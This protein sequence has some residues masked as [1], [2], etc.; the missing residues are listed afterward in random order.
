[1]TI[2]GPVTKELC[3]NTAKER[4]SATFLDAT[5]ATDGMQGG[6]SSFFCSAIG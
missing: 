6:K 5:S 2:T 1:M 3:Q 4:P